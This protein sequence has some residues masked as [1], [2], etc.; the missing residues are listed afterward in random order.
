MLYNNLIINK[1]YVY[2][3]RFVN[4]VSSAI[5]SIDYS[6]YALI[7]DGAHGVNV[8]G[9]VIKK[10]ENGDTNTYIAAFVIGFVLI[11]LIFVL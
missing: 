2:T 11:L 4:A 7:K 3:I 5:Y 1:A 10:I 6:L 9:D 8:F